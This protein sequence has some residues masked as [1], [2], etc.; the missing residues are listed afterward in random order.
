MGGRLRRQWDLDS[1]A[2]R[3]LDWTSADAAGLPILPGLVRYDEVAAGHIF[4]ALRFTAPT[5]RKAYLYPARHY[6]SSSTEHQPAADGPADPPQGDPPTWPACRRRRR[7]SRSPS[8]A[9]G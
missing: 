7:R 6:A 5:T 8:S 2:L 4:H 9:T 1:N 3:P